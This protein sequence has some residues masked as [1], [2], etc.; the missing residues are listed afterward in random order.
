M[1]TEEQKNK[2]ILARFETK[3]LGNSKVYTGLIDGKKVVMIS[4]ANESINDAIQSFCD[5]FGKE[6]FGGLV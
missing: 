5:K 1:I 3:S 2:N 6:R 4:P